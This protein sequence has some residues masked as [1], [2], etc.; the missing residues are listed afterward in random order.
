MAGVYA[1]LAAIMASRS[2]SLSR[3]PFN[4]DIVVIKRASFPK[5]EVPKHLEKFLIKKGECSGKTGTLIHKGRL[6]P[7][8]AVCVAAKHG[9]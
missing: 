6:V 5:G 1:N 8:T 9:K 3:T 7:A 4:P 2:M